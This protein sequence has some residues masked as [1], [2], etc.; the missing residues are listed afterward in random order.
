VTSAEDEITGAP[1]AA[2]DRQQFF[3]HCCHGVL[4]MVEFQA[5]LFCA[6]VE[7]EIAESGLSQFG[8]GVRRGVADQDVTAGIGGPV[9]PA[10]EDVQR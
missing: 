1:T 10:G 5:A 9:V 2:R 6:D 8:D 7:S 3:L 4:A